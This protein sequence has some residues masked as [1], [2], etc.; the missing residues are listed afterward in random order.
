MNNQYP[1]W[2]CIVVLDFCS[3][4]ADADTPTHFSSR[5]DGLLLPAG[6]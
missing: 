6:R 4:Y 5:I 3:V 2:V 1:S